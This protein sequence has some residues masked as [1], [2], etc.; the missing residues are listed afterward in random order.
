M[1]SAARLFAKMPAPVSVSLW[2]A[3]GGVLGTLARHGVDKLL[4]PPP[5]AHPGFPWPTFLIN[6]S[7]SALLGFILAWVEE[8]EHPPRWLRPGVGIG[9]CGAYTTFST[10]SVEILLLARDGQV[11]VA[12]TYL[13]ASVVSALL[14]VTITTAIAVKIFAGPRSMEGKIPT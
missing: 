9:F 6:V 13:A 11:S 1:K 10:A 12:L 14:A 8:I 5:S 3:C 7:G 2:V 4:M